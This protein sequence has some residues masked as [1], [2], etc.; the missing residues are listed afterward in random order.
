MSKG[1]VSETLSAPSFVSFQEQLIRSL[2][3]KSLLLIRNFAF[4]LQATAT[5]FILWSEMSSQFFC[6]YVS[7]CMG[8]HCVG[9]WKKLLMARLICSALHFFSTGSPMHSDQM[10]WRKL[11]D[12]SFFTNRL[13]SYPI[14]QLI[15]SLTQAKVWPSLFKGIL[16][17]RFSRTPR[18]EFH[19]CN[20]KEV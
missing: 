4:T 15:L 1:S 11:L 16:K 17:S 9:C 14:W 7:M 2:H 20:E 18:S 12:S 10:G 3:S 5:R 13:G 19:F 6:M 8:G